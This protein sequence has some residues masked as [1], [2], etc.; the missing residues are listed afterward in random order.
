MFYVYEHWRPDVN[1]CFYV[2]KGQR[3]RAYRMDR[4]NQRHMNIQ[5]ALAVAGLSVEVRIIAEDLTEDEAF[6]MERERI[7]MWR[8]LRTAL[9]NATDGGD[10]VSGFSHSAETRKKISDAHVGRRLSPEH[11]AAM[12]RTLKGRPSK[13]IHLAMAAK[14]GKPTPPEVRAKM[15]ESQKRGW[16][17][18]EKRARAAASAQKRFQDPEVR[19]KAK[20]QLQAYYNRNRSA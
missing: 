17:D 10:G 16:S 13:T 20:A 4:R 9:C 3:K 19:K 1:S 12:S 6:C 18:P 5:S 11:C 15:S 2:G 7:V 8:T 14:R